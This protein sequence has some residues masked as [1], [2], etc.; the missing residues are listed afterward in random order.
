MFTHCPLLM[1]SLVSLYTITPISG[2]PVDARESVCRRLL[3][4]IIAKVESNYAGYQLEVKANPERL[5]RYNALKV[6]LHWRATTTQ[7]DEC[8]WLLRDYVRWFGDAH[9]FV[10]EY[11][12]FSA[13]RLKEFKASTPWQPT[14]G[15]VE[16]LTAVHD[17]LDA[18]EGLWFTPEHEIAVTRTSDEATPTTFVAVILET[19]SPHW[20]TGDV[21]AEFSKHGSLYRSTLRMDDHSPR[22]YEAR[23][24]HGLLLHMAP[25]S[26]G[27]R[28]PLPDHEKGTL[29]PQDPRAPHFRVLGTDATV[30]SLPSLS[31]QY[32]Q[33]LQ[34]ICAEQRV[35]ITS[36][37]VLII[38]LRGNEG[39]SSTA[40]R[41]LA[42]FFYGDSLRPPLRAAGRPHVLSCPDT[43]AYYDQQKSGFFT[44]SWLKSI[45]RRLRT[46]PG[47]LIP[48]YE[49]D[50]GYE[51]YEPRQRH[52]RPVHVAILVDGNVI[53]A[54]EAFLIDAKRH[55]KVKVFGRNTGG[56][57]DY[58][59]VSI[60]GI[61]FGRHSYGL[62]YPIIAASE[63]L[64]DGGF[65]ADGIPPDVVFG[66]SVQDSIRAIREHYRDAK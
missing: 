24:R 33:P 56:T 2:Q 31:P 59:N 35:A 53:S 44:P 17:R 7:D 65:N 37:D 21:L 57:I 5:Q 3:G 9:L 27:R 62:G 4:Q 23:I 11:P 64:P 63:N 26:W 49:K 10:Q 46:Q 1:A 66:S 34:K 20:Q 18:I 42:P 30:I 28:F 52:A 50:K 58:Q 32:R 19:T 55:R 16:R 41:P 39:G 43:I 36:R 15:L 6:E 47:Q 8:L 51:P 48:L 22:R 61:G 29:H 45:R 38:D 25:Y 12:V 14:D 40:A 54:G 13:D 60:V